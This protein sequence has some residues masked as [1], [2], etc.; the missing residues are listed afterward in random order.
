[1]AA[2]AM[3]LC[4]VDTALRPR[5]LPGVSFIL[6]PFEFVSQARQGA[7]FKLRLYRPLGLAWQRWAVFAQS[8]LGVSL[9]GAKTITETLRHLHDFAQARFL[10]GRRMAQGKF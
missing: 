1:M 8:G 4:S 2:A 6:F 9:S 3:M 5:S 10:F 7:A